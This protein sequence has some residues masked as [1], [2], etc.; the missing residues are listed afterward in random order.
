MVNGLVNLNTGNNVDLG[1]T[2]ELK[3]LQ[4]SR[5]DLEDLIQCQRGRTIYISFFNPLSSLLLI[6]FF[7]TLMVL[8]GNNHLLK[9]KYFTHREIRAGEPM[10]TTIYNQYKL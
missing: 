9:K 10:I 2:V 3:A 4:I 6:N 1:R 7:E 5:E 8:M